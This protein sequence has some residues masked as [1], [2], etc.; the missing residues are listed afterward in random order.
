MKIAMDGSSLAAAIYVRSDDI[1]HSKAEI[2]KQ[3]Y[4]PLRAG[5]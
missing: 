4:Q 3:R 1:R 2:F 5:D